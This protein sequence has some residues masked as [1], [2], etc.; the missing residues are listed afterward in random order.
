MEQKFYCLHALAH[1]TSAFGLGN[2]EK[3]PEFSSM[4]LPTMSLQLKQ[5]CT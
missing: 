2:R 1:A 3:T 4:M 5:K